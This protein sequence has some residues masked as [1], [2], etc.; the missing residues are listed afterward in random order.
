MKVPG[1]IYKTFY[2]KPEIG[3]LVNYTKLQ[4]KNVSLDCT[5]LSGKALEADLGT[6]AIQIVEDLTQKFG[7][8]I[9]QINRA[10]S[11][12]KSVIG[13]QNRT[14]TVPSVYAKIMRGVQEGEV[15]TFDTAKSFILDGIG[16]RIL[17]K[18]L[19][20]L[21]KNKINSMV[22]NLKV[23]EKELTKEQK[24]LLKKYI[25]GHDLTP[26]Q[27]IEVL[28]LFE[29]F[30]QPLIEKRSQP[31]VDNLL[32]SIAKSRMIKDGL[33]LEEIKTK[34]LL[35][36]ELI[37][38]LQTET[39]EPL[40]ITLMNNYRGIHGLPEFSS[41]QIQSIR[42]MTEDRLIIHSRPDLVD[43][44]RFPNEGYTKDEIKEFALKHSGYRTAQANVIHS[45]GA[46]G[47]IQFRGE[48]TNRFAEYEHLAYDLRQGKNTLGPIFDDFKAAISSLDDK[49]YSEYNLYLEKCYN[50]YYR[51][52]LGLPAVKPK[53]PDKFDKILSD[54]SLKM[55]HDNN[56]ALLA[57]MSINF[58]PYFTVVA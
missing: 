45:N 36:E 1:T 9:A 21:S 15:T 13:I 19:P 28:P 52:E 42:K 31:V 50:Y 41:K 27:E 14:K 34:G 33:T 37:K 11:G 35:S 57:S 18:S 22:N 7:E 20:K 8:A 49:N 3:V 48:L 58:E 2:Q 16:S 30:A 38:R 54:D 5:K 43:Y 40:D 25:Y 23:G 6:T 56:E 26:E 44:D 10:F 47:E 12:L 24:I 29:K 55:L 32:L 4:A 17:S 46:L 53:L 39:I 51:L